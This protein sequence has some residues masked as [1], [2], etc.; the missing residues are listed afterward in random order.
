M[1]AS[2]QTGTRSSTRSSRRS[3]EMPEGLADLELEELDLATELLLT[4]PP[5]A[6]K[7]KNAKKVQIALLLSPVPKAIAE[8][9]QP[10][11]E[12]RQAPFCR[13]RTGGQVVSTTVEGD[14]Q[15]ALPLTPALSCAS[16]PWRRALEL[17][18]S[19]LI[20]P[21]DPGLAKEIKSSA[22]RPP[23]WPPT[24]TA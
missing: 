12:F 13:H 5:H 14:Q 20:E 4:P 1:S 17:F 23:R 7:K 2:A 21:V 6:E 3:E 19:P 22:S 9:F 16:T 8:G 18:A 11:H 10:Y 24:A 15:D